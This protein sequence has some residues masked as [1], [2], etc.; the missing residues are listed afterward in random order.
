MSWYAEQVNDAKK[1]IGEKGLSA[2][3]IEAIYR[4][5]E[6]RYRTSDVRIH[7]SDDFDWDDYYG[8]DIAAIYDNDEEVMQIAELFLEE[9]QDCNIDEN[10]AFAECISNYLSS[11]RE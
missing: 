3:D 10:T 6:M 1:V 2:A 8:V 5:Q 7:L 4:Y 9:Y 11:Y